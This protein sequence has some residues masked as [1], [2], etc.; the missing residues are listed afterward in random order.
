MQT[1]RENIQKS[2]SNRLGAEARFS[3]ALKMTPMIDMIFLLLIFLLV[4]GKWRP[5][6]NFLPLKMPTAQASEQTMPRPEPLIIKISATKTGC[7]ASIDQNEKIKIE[8]KNIEANLAVLLK[9]IQDRL[10]Q[11]KR[12]ASDPVEIICS[13][14]LKW[15][16]LAKIYNSLFGAG[17]TDITFQMTE[18]PGNAPHK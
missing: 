15:D 13:P 18:P 16:H 4:A 2:L 6:E 1:A 10:K 7:V 3:Y 5:A 11:Q 14:D 8:N 17:I 12:Y 9:K